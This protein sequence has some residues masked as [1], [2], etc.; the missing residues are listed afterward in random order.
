MKAIELKDTR[1]DD[2]IP[3]QVQ[4]EFW[5]YVN[6]GTPSTEILGKWMIFK[7][8]FEL[9]KVW[10]KVK[11]AV[12]TGTLGGCKSAKCSTLKYNPST[13]GTG[14]Q[15]S[16]V[17]CVY[18]EKW[19]MDE[20]G[21]KAVEIAQEDIRYKTDAATLSGQY[22]HRTREKVTIKTIFWNNGKPSL[23]RDK[24]ARNFKSSNRK[25]DIWHLNVV[26]GPEPV[27]SEIIFGKWIIFSLEP[28]ELTDC[29][30]TL[31]K[32]IES[33]SENFGA[34]KMVCPPS[35]RSPVFHVYT[36][37]ERKDSVGWKLIN[38]VRSDIKYVYEMWRTEPGSSST[39]ALYWNKGNPGYHRT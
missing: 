30:H 27:C 18:T 13:A 6:N 23:I 3:T 8:Y 2:D 16:G 11:N 29:W 24:S 25:E 21:F 31:K 35:T 15:N 4:H 1:E 9:D 22:S 33:K 36:S 17:I 7:H 37:K 28:D 38:I 20:I 10:D 12:L 39:D 32:P 14:P 19:N 5:V 34:I 26:K